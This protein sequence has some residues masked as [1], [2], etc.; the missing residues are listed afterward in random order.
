MTYT[1]K[2]ASTLRKITGLLLDKIA[3]ELG[4]IDAELDL[5]K[6]KFLLLTPSGTSLGASGIDLAS[7]TNKEKHGFFFPVDVTILKMHDY[8]TEAYVK[9]TDEAKIEVYAEDGTPTKLF[10]RGLTD[11][12]AAKTHT[13]TDPE[14]DE[15]DIAAGMGISLKATNTQS[16]S[17]TGHAAVLVEYVER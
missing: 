6:S 16:G 9:D 17:G 10:G 5:H 8:L 13:Q 12:E 7:G 2:T 3:T 1:A 11:G 4:L 15:E 14:T